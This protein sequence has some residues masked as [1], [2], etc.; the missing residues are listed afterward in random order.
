MHKLTAT[1]ALFTL[2]LS[3]A[4][5]ALGDT[6]RISDVNGFLEFSKRVN[7]GSSLASS[8]VILDG[9]IEFTDELSQQ[10]T[11]IND[12][13]LT[14]SHRFRG[15]FD[16]QG[17]TIRNLKVNIPNS[18]IGIFGYV[19]DNITIR[20]I[21]VDSSCSFESNTNQIA[22][23]GGIVGANAGQGTTFTIENCVNMAS[24]SFTGTSNS[25]LYMGGI[26]GSLGMSGVSHTT[27]CANYGAITHSGEVTGTETQIG[28]IAGRLGGLYTFKNFIH[29][30]VNYGAVT[31]SGT[32][33]APHIGGIIGRLF[34]GELKNCLSAGSVTTATATEYIG[35]ISGS[36]PFKSNISDCYWTS[37]VGSYE[38][39]GESETEKRDGTITRTSLSTSNEETLAAL[40]A[41][42]EA[43]S[44]SKWLLITNGATASLKAN[45][46]G[47]AVVF[48]FPF[49]PLFDLENE[50]R[51]FDGWYDGESE[52]TSTSISENKELTGKF[53]SKD[54]TLSFDF[55][56]GT[57]LNE[58]HVS[59]DAI[60]YPDVA[61]T[62]DKFFVWDKYITTMPGEDTVVRGTWMNNSRYVEITFEG[63][64]LS[65]GDADEILKKYTT[66]DFTIVK[67]EEDAT[68]T[69][70]TIKFSST[71]KATNFI[72]T[73]MRDKT[74]DDQIVKIE[75][76]TDYYTP[77]TR[78]TLTF[79][80]G[81]GTTLNETHVSGDAITYPEVAN[82][83]EKFFSGWDNYITTMPDED[84]VIRARWTKT[85]KYVEII[86]GR[87]DLSE[88]EVKEM[89]QKY[90]GDDFTV[91]RFEIDG[92]EGTTSV[93]L[94]FQSTA[95]AVE[96]IE[97][98]YASSDMATSSIISISFTYPY[99][100][101]S[102]SGSEE[103]SSSK[104]STH[105]DPD[106]SS[107]SFSSSLRPLALLFL[108]R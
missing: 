35:T 7:S 100:E 83:A 105:A 96:F 12:N 14:L 38:I 46:N 78:Y 67:L 95:D 62:A 71:T 89:I 31:V 10:F 88:E 39:S 101:P 27:N 41:N 76:V 17:Y 66:D 72:R 30:C 58:T 104:G 33:Q 18:H 40:N 2:G 13:P 81:N 26:A 57:T 75:T 73:A 20:N 86:F 21:V 97:T 29:N 6:V 82:T 34:L 90:T 16:G 87:K 55:G 42:A 61:D 56:N 93:I 1:T 84:T 28:G 37:D 44:W 108:I 9:D 11:P 47:K 50:W 49:A 63:R 92:E 68:S 45:S 54:Y 106:S 3:A 64:D 25:Y 102:Y 43:N 77:S 107:M 103:S 22:Y 74:P 59:G 51:R 98:V 60:T 91:E 52:F 19:A 8:T 99:V 94:K 24:L 85:S 69:E 23:I 5:T 70:I 80:F 15:L 79:D 48:T 36:A 53:T 32:S 65:E 4:T